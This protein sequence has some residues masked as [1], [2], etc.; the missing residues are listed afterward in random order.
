MA[1][2]KPTKAKARP[3]QAVMACTAPAARIRKAR[4]K[5]TKAQLVS[6]GT[7]TPDDLPFDLSPALSGFENVQSRYADWVVAQ[8]ADPSADVDRKKAWA[9][10]VMEHGL[11]PQCH[12]CKQAIVLKWRESGE[13][14]PRFQNY[15]WH[16]KCWRDHRAD[17]ED[18]KRRNRRERHRQQRDDINARRRS[19]YA[20]KRAAT[21]E[22]D[23]LQVDSDND[24]T[25][26]AAVTES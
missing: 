25:A 13:H 18:R 8:T 11:H 2:A 26:P 5:P 6:F 4:A 3:S 20:D 15:I 1:K 22:Q 9:L 24:C 19:R 10:A 17:V 12:G 14:D 23:V 21:R 16:A 7:K